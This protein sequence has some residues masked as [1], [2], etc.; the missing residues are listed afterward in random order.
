MLIIG[1]KRKPDKCVKK[2]TTNVLVMWLAM[3]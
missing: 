2:S 1:Y 3:V